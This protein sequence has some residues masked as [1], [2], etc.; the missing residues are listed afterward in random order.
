MQIEFVHEGIDNSYRVI[1]RDELIQRFRQ[2]RHLVPILTFDEP[3]HTDFVPRYA[4]NSRPSLQ[5]KG[6]GFHTSSRDAV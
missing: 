4:L 6:L 3:W 2:Q 1:V 5:F